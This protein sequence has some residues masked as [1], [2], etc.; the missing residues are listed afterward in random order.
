M[1]VEKTI[2]FLIQ[3][4]AAHDERLTRLEHT[5]QVLVSVVGTLSNSYVKLVEA[6]EILTTRMDTLTARVDTLT[7]RVDTIAQ[8][9]AER[10]RVLGER[11]DSL[12]SAIGEFIR[13][14]PATG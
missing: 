13:N 9:S 7:A 6:M 4:Q 8:Q 2:E 12:V 5:S 10:D 14:K 3:N 11:L 1:D